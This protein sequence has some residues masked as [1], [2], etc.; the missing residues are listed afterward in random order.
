MYLCNLWKSC[1]LKLSLKI[2]WFMQWDCALFSPKCINLCNTEEEFVKFEKRAL[3]ITI[4]WSYLQAVWAVMHLYIDFSLCLKMTS[5]YEFFTLTLKDLNKLKCN[6]WQQRFL[7][8]ILSHVWVMYATMM[9][10]YHLHSLSSTFTVRKLSGSKGKEKKWWISSAATAQGDAVGWPA[11]GVCTH[12]GRDSFPHHTQLL[13][14]AKRN[15]CKLLPRCWVILKVAVRLEVQR[16]F[17]WVP[18]TVVDSG[19]YTDLVAGGNTVAS[20]SLGGKRQDPT[21]HTSLFF[22][23]DS[24]TWSSVIMGL[25]PQ[26]RFWLSQ[27][28]SMQHSKFYLRFA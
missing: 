22:S 11:Q 5:Y 10:N 12:S 25:R 2:L 26:K 9:Q 15:I 8:S 23:F 17:P 6:I 7:F 3:I 18:Q 28:K 16:V 19:R 13:T 1:S 27:L 14:S 20:N 4:L 21:R 24:V